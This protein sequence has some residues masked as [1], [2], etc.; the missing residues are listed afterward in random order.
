MITSETWRAW[1]V[2]KLQSACK[3]VFLCICVSELCHSH[4]LQ[5]VRPILFVQASFNCLISFYE[6]GCL[7]SCSAMGIGSSG[8]G[9][10]MCVSGTGVTLANISGC[11]V[12]HNS[13]VLGGGGLYL[14]GGATL[15]SNN[16][17]QDNHA[18]MGRGGAAAY[19]K[20]CFATTGRSL[21]AAAC[22]LDLSEH[23]WSGSIDS[24][25]HP[26]LCMHIECPHMRGTSMQ[27]RCY[28]CSVPHTT[29][30]RTRIKACC[31]LT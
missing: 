12:A 18:L 13:A 19:I 4:A 6:L 8:N 16:M 5:C 24:D 14:D 10:G 11:T 15:L 20:E 3:S 9:G 25:Q 17:F 31:T 30:L 23:V 7:C 29:F 22:F 1:C 27:D 28:A 2:C 21:N 26:V